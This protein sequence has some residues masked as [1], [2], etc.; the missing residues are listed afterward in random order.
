MTV[1]PGKFGTAYTEYRTYEMQFKDDHGKNVVQTITLDKPTYT[2]FRAKVEKAKMET[3]YA[4]WTSGCALRALLDYRRGYFGIISLC[5]ENP[6]EDAFGTIEA[7]S[8]SQ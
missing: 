3:A 2:K 7:D 1:V 4:A 5:D 6:G 8:N